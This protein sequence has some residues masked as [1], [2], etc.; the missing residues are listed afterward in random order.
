MQGQ[1]TE[2]AEEFR[3]ALKLNPRSGIARDNLGVALA[4]NPGEALLNWQSINEPATAHS[5]LAAVLIE[6]GKYAE[7]RHEL[8]IALQYNKSNSAAIANLK[9]VSDVDGKPV[10]L[11]A[12]S[13]ATHWSRMRS[14]WHR[15]F[16]G[17]ATVSPAAQ[18]S[19]QTASQSPESKP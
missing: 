18:P 14:S 12:Q 2:A 13:A 10:T 8:E 19:I 6:Q 11:P 5:N 3:A 15:W 7:A 1:K 16:S 4:D 17:S 9:L